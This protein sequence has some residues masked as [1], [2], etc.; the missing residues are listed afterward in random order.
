L[1][2][3]IH[4]NLLIG[5]IVASLVGIIL[6]AGYFFQ[7]NM[8]QNQTK[9]T[10]SSH[11]S[12]AHTN[13]EPHDN[14]ETKNTT[15]IVQTVSNPVIVIA[16]AQA[17]QQPTEKK[18]DILDDKTEF[19]K[20]VIELK[21]IVTN[22]DPQVAL[23]KIAVDVQ[24]NKLVQNRCHSLTHIVGNQALEKFQNN[25]TQALAFSKE[26]C[27][28]GYM[29]GLVEKFISVSQDPD[30]EIV[31]LCDS[32]P[33]QS[34]CYHGLGHGIMIYKKY[35]ANESVNICSNINSNS[36][37]VSC[38]EGVFMEF[39][40]SESAAEAA[41]KNTI[42]YNPNE[43]CDGY[44]SLY[45]DTCYYYAGRYIYNT[46]KIESKSLETC[47]Q[48]KTKNIDSCVRGM[49]AGIVR[50]HLLEANKMEEY[51]QFAED[52]KP[53]CYT[54]AVNYH[55]FIIG[56]INK[57]ENEMCNKLADPANKQICLEKI[58]ISPFR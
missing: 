53:T 51:C 18:T 48:F 16:E 21:N 8:S 22:Q 7:Q 3:K 32:S 58:R 6:C 36:F 28:S 50:N 24:T 4:K 42:V 47:L 14:I 10:E 19:Q 33:I 15:P 55:L 57:T 37:Q 9:A 20:Y 13:K 25:I 43:V 1:K 29:H 30:N 12:V 38:G 5:I 45:Q 31:A 17:V 52:Y 11:N 40:D 23:N 39:F 2:T 27:G 41:E 56:D 49:S 44:N 35:N 46:I 26:V 34:I 54:G